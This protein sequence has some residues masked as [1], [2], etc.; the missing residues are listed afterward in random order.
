MSKRLVMADA[1]RGLSRQLR[2]KRREWRASYGVDASFYKIAN[3]A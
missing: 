3:L 2:V 1:L